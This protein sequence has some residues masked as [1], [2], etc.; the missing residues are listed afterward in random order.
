MDAIGRGRHIVAGRCS[1]RRAAGRTD[2]EGQVPV[3]SGDL[4]QA[5]GR[6]RGIGIRIATADTSRT[7]DSLGRKAAHRIG[8]A[9]R[10]HV[11]GSTCSSRRVILRITTLSRTALCRY[12]DRQWRIHLGSMSII[13]NA[14]SFC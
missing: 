8:P 14:I 11:I 3:D 6:R 13:S 4:R 12:R 2:I 1:Q 10:T 7:T 9:Q 5:I